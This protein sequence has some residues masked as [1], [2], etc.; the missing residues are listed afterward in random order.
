MWEDMSDGSQ[1]I[2]CQLSVSWLTQCG[3]TWMTAA[4]E[5]FVSCSTHGWLS[6][7]RLGSRWLI[8]KGSWLEPILTQCGKKCYTLR[9]DFDHSNS[10][11]NVAGCFCSLV[12]RCLCSNGIFLIKPVIH[13][14]S[15]THICKSQ[16]VH[17][18]S[19]SGHLISGLVN[20]SPKRQHAI[21]TN[22]WT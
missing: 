17:H 8:Q 21:G 19:S 10:F 22:N 12:P 9:H 2:F 1:R 11:K 15:T 16:H 14:S 4:S 6:V 13:S 5:S 3:K 18:A 7:G 20:F